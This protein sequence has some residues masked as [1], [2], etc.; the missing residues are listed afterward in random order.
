MSLIGKYAQPTL[1]ISVD[2]TV[3][4]EVWRFPHHRIRIAKR[5][6]ILIGH[7]FSKRAFS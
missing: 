1:Q 5:E 3:Y 2:V 7:R 4:R 6:S